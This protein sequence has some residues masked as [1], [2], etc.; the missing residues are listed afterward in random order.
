MRAVSLL[1]IDLIAHTL[2][3]IKL[4]GILMFVVVSKAICHPRTL[5]DIPPD[6]LVDFL[7]TYDTIGTFELHR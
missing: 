4:S 1:S 2:S 7:G 6:N 5:S 3:M